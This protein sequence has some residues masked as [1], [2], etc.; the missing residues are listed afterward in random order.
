MANVA[1]QQQR[2][3]MV[4]KPESEWTTL[5]IR[6][7]ADLRERIAQVAHARDRSLGYVCVQLLR[8]GI[9]RLDAAQD[10]GHK[11]QRRRSR[12]SDNV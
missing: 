4:N 12:P 10:D 11:G 8:A 5:N 3:P 9:E 7:P 2:L 6:M 1:S